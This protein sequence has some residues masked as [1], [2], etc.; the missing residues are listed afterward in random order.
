MI[1]RRY[2][3]QRNA[4]RTI[5][6]FPMVEDVGRVAVSIVPGEVTYAIVDSANVAVQ[7]SGN[8]TIVDTGLGYSRID[9]IVNPIATLGES[10]RLTISWRRPLEVL[11]QARTQQIRFDV[12]AQEWVT[13]VTLDTMR[14][15]FAPIAERLAKQGR[16]HTPALTAEQVA[17]IRISDAQDGFDNVLRRV[18]TQG[19]IQS[20]ASLVPDPQIFDRIVAH[21]SVALTFK[22]D[23]RFDLMERFVDDAMK[24]FANLTLVGYDADQNFVEDDEI[25]APDRSSAFRNEFLGGY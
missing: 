5:S 17:S 8:A 1:R 3:V 23:L 7:A 4:Q 20:R 22:S 25:I 2:E 14:S 18:I 12:V 24:S 15:L 9:C 19:R 21:L 6:Y 11:A 13:E 10:Y 16:Y